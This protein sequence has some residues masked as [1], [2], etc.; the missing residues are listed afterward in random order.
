MSFLRL[1]ARLD[2]KGEKLIKS[3]QL[4]GV[5]VL[6]DPQE[7]AMRYYK[8]G[9]DELL[10][11]D[12]VASLY[13][14]NSIA[15]TVKYTAENIFIPLTV[16][17]GIRSLKDVEAMLRSGADKV[18]INTAVVH[19]PELITEI[20][21]RF[22]AQCMVLQVD[23]K[24]NADIGWEVYIDGG[25]ERTSRDVIQWVSEAVDRGAGEVLVT[26]ID[27]EGTRQGM[28]LALINEVINV[29]SVPVIASG[30][31]GSPHDFLEG[32]MTGCNAVAVADILHY[33]RAT[34][35]DLRTKA[36]REGLSVRSDDLAV[37]L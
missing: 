13:G 26:S 3:V 7:Y 33:E 18:A 2:I 20:S 36:R 9:A 10:Y 16:G 29:S 14:R 32:A 30:G 5:R 4:E 34:I 28:D 27:K 25:R 17:G 1:V 11:M 19:D 8:S 31:V 24:R 6:G 37:D 35:S 21:R 12:A 22:G 23:A 15:E